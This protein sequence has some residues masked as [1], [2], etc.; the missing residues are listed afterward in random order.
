MPRVQ[1]RPLPCITEEIRDKI[2]KLIR[3]VPGETNCHPWMGA[4]TSRGYGTFRINNQIYYA[5]RLI[6]LIET[7]KDPFPLEMRHNCDNPPCTRFSHLLTGNHQQNMQD[8]VE[9]KRMALGERNGTHTHPEKRLHGENNP[10]VVVPDVVV[11]QIRNAFANGKS[12]SQ[13]AREVGLSPNA[14]VKMVH[15]QHRKTASGPIVSG[16]LPRT[17]D[18]APNRILTSELV[19]DLLRRRAEGATFRELEEEFGVT[20]GSI[21]PILDGVTWKEVPRDA[22]KI[23]K[24]KAH[25][26]PEQNE[27]IK[28]KRASGVSVQALA[29]EYNVSIGAIY[30]ILLK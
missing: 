15:G 23:P 9:R 2:V 18:R 29:Q 11:E 16:H 27:E 25:L 26:T 12:C 22:Y 3:V 4:R 5:T 28:T 20:Q 14:V 21:V 19:A 8:A 24:R 7:G 1:C 13:L 10:G 17:G 30:A 6:W